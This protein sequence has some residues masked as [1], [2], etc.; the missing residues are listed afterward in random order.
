MITGERGIKKKV[1]IPLNLWLVVITRKH[2]QHNQDR[3]YN[4]QK[5]KGTTST[6]LQ[7]PKITRKHKHNQEP[8]QL[9]TNT[10]KTD[11]TIS[12]STCCWWLQDARCIVGGW[13]PCG[14]LGALWVRGCFVTKRWRM[15]CS[16][17]R[18]GEWKLAGPILRSIPWYLIRTHH[19]YWQFNR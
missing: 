9:T 10:T 11:A 5:W 15:Y 12:R 14:W 6:T 4:I 3:R 18:V 19:F 2:K 16:D 13:V 7:Y 1:N 8:A 17:T